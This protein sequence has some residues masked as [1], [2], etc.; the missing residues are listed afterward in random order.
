MIDLAD[1]VILLGAVFVC[2]ALWM[3]VGWAG[4]LAFVGIVLLVI[5]LAKEFYRRA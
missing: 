3:A 1:V 2:A 5:G 4:V